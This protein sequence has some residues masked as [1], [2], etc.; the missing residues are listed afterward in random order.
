MTSEGGSF[1]RLKGSCASLRGSLVNL[2]DTVWL[3]VCY[4]LRASFVGLREPSIGLRGPRLVVLCRPPPE[5]ALFLQNFFG[6]RG[7]FFDP[8]GSSVSRSGACALLRWFYVCLRGFCA[9]PRAPFA[10]LRVSSFD[11]T[12][13]CSGLRGPSVGLGVFSV[14]LREACA[15]PKMS[16]DD[17]QLH[18]QMIFLPGFKW[19]ACLAL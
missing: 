8:R 5:R 14:G 7:L 6:L 1:V 10:D 9:G 16:S 12:W 11:L 3:E 19:L 4:S 17:F 13:L 15:D 18:P 2:R